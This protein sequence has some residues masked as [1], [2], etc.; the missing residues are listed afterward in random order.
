MVVLMVVLSPY[1]RAPLLVVSDL[2]RFEIHTNFTA[3]PTVVF[4]FDLDHLAEPANL[5]VLRK[6]FSEPQA[7]EP[8]ETTEA[9]T[10]EVAERFSELAEGMRIRNVPAEKAAHLPMK[11][12]FCMF[13]EDIELL[14]DKLF[15]KLLTG[16]ADNPDRLTRQ[17]QQLFQAMSKGGDFGSDA[18]LH[19][20]GGLFADADVIELI[21]AEFRVLSNAN[22]RDWSNVFL[23]GMGPAPTS[24]SFRRSSGDLP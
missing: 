9:I 20:N 5:D 23:P 14:P 17:L 7:L 19:F 3:K 22:D 4:A 13:A 2:D 15:T 24:K 11:L 6:V 18:I 8:G 12:M 21:Q 10:Q 1:G 16:S